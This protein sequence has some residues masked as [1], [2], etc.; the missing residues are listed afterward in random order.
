MFSRKFLKLM[1]LVIVA[2]C[3]MLV[4]NDQVSAQRPPPRTKKKLVTITQADRE[5]AAARAAKLGLKLGPAKKT[6][7]KAPTGLAPAGVT[8]AALA[9]GTVPHYFGPFPNYANSPLPSG[10]VS[11]IMIENGGTGY[12][13]TPTVII[14]DVYGTGTGAT[15]S[16]TVIGGVIAGITI[17]NGGTGY[18]APFV[19]ITDAT[20][21]NAAV[22]VS[23]GGFAGGVVSVGN[24]LIAR[25]NATDSASNVFVVNNHALPTGQ[26]SAIEIYNQP[27]SGSK[28]FTA[29]VLRPTGVANQYTVIFDSGLLSVPSVAT[30]QVQ[31]FPVGPFNVQAGDLIAHYGQ[32]IPLD[33]GAGGDTLLYPAAPAPAMNQTVTLGTTYPI[34]PQARTYSIAASVNTG[35]IS[36]GIRKFVD[37]LPGLGPTN[38]NNLGQ[39][40]PVAVPDACTYSGVAADCYV[41]ELREYTEKMHS[42]LL[43]TKMR[44]YVQIKNGVDA[45]PI[46]YLGPTIVA[47]KDRAV[48]I[49]FR[50]KLPTGAGGNLFLPVD[51]TVMGAGEG[52]LDV[53]GMPGMKES[54]K[55][56]RATLHLHGGLV[57]WISDGTSQ[58]WTTPA[59]E[60][61]QYPKGVAVRDVPDMPATGPGEMTFYYNN[62]Q[63][64]RLM[65]YHDHSWG[66][67][68]LNVYGGEAAG[69]VLTDQVEQDMIGGTNASGVNPGL[70]RV[71]PDIG[72]PLVIQDRSFIDPKTLAYQD[73]TWPFPLDSARSDLWYPHVYMPNQNPGDL[74]GM[75][76][77]GRWHYTPWFWP[78]TTGITHGPVANPYYDCGAGGACTRPWEPPLIPGT[79]DLSMA[80]EGF[81]DTPIV[82]GTAYPYLVVDPKAVRFRVLNAANDRFWNLQLY[83]ADPNVTTVDGRT[84][85]EVKLVPAPTGVAGY[86]A[87]YM[88]AD[89]ALAGPSFIQIGT[90]GGFLPKPVVLPNKPIGW[91]GDPTN[92]DM[93]VVNKGTLILA[94]AERADVVVDFSAFAGKTLILYNDSP[95]PFPALDARYDYYTGKG[96]HTDTGGT[97]DTLAGFGPNTRTVMQIQVR[98]VAPAPAYDLAAL[99]GVFAKSAA[100]SGVFE[101]S[102][103]PI[104]LPNTQ[105]NSA[106]N[107]TFASEAVT[108]VGIADKSKTF[109]TVSGATLTIPFEPKSIHDEASEVFD[110]YGRMSGMLG[111]TTLGLPGFAPY[112][113][114]SPP[115]DILKFTMTPMSEPAPGDGTQIWKITHNGVDTHPIHFHLFN[116]QLINRVAWDNATR[117]PDPN[118]LGWKD[119]VR[120]NPL[121]DT[122]VALRPVAP[123][124]PFKMTNSERVIDP[125]MPQGAT[126]MGPL[127]GGFQN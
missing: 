84:N 105:Y 37:S 20:G 22:T 89:P 83:V 44:G 91:N 117:L 112:P 69:Y 40:L 21:V 95:A 93:G 119:T 71:L 92:F 94:P 23:I 73:P 43:P 38:A 50:N 60:T 39:Y 15:A 51:T 35:T 32:G 110:D 96:D 87:G 8:A 30:A 115:V 120:I 26:L 109:N 36:G 65:F 121:Q 48:R 28:T 61:T 24:S 88:V 25:A 77:F 106:Y 127:P 59:G 7:S 14:E 41:I 56:N 107:K 64:A 76:A 53:P 11:G 9:P 102:Q 6:A 10:P 70:A 111:L 99:N 63:S 67:T 125:S 17:T 78:P 74:S 79:P 68:R 12:S 27:G 13:A 100:K 126:L 4:G 58:Q 81:M 75:N 18:T 72:I 123:T 114:A 124:Q 33:I 97:P 85:T 42:D 86:P 103:E 62:Q 19:T 34:Y 54:Y 80:V 57:P 113:F 49:T 98:N 29:Y 108:K 82:N 66:I 116:V 2:A 101:K 5:A 31:S 1:L 104:I 90:E 47:Q 3:L 122:I 16:A 52:P 45:A 46:H 118:E 55:Q